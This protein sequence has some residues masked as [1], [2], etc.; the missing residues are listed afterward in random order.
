VEIPAQVAVVREMFRL[1][2][3]GLGSKKIALQ[4]NS[5]LA[6]ATIQK[7][8]ASRATLGEYQPH[9]VVNGKRLPDGDP[10]AGYYPAIIS[11]SE[12]A[13]A[14]AEIDRKNTMP[15]G[16]RQFCSKNDR[17]DNLF[18]GLLFDVTDKPERT[19]VFQKK[20]AGH[21]AVL[22]SAYDRLDHRKSH[23]FPYAKFE[24][25]FLELLKDLDWKAIA[26][27]GKSD[28]E[29]QLQKRLDAK[30]AELDRVERRIGK[31]KAAM[32]SEDV[33][34][35][36]LRI[37]ARKLDA[38]E[39]LAAT[40]TE[41]KDATS[42]SLEAARAQT[43]VL[44][45]P[46]ALI[47][48]ISDPSNTEMRLRARTEI[49]KRVS[50]IDFIFHKNDPGLFAGIVS[51]NN[52]ALRLITVVGDQVYVMRIPSDEVPVTEDELRKTA[53]LLVFS[54]ERRK[55]ATVKVLTA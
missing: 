48:A 16:R 28:D 13:A 20:Q 6:I 14:R 19:L 51:F 25:A 40:L 37:L 22:V 35:G 9:R 3:L 49:R 52:K 5:G 11:P 43:Q 30:L 44:A 24:R 27:K 50:R 47:E 45:E 23:R 18:T 1:A 33:E 39:T 42:A 54:K 46:Q 4:I 29:I 2:A 21:N 32:D 15:D 36:E 31:T 34:P 38:D 8:L 55:A 26:D 53:K 10:I 7:T 12:W 41:E 17:A